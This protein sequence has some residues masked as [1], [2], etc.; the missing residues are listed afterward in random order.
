MPADVLIPA[1]VNTMTCLE[2]RIQSDKVFTFSSSSERSS[3][4][5]KKHYNLQSGFMNGEVKLD[6][7]SGSDVC[8]IL[9]KLFSETYAAEEAEEGNAFLSGK[10]QDNCEELLQ[11]IVRKCEAT[12]YSPDPL[13]VVTDF[14]LA[15]IRA[16]ETTFGP[17]VEIGM[18]NHELVQG[19]LVSSIA[20]L[21]HGGGLKILREL[22]K[23]KLVSYERGYRYD[24]YRLTNRGYDFLALRVLCSRNVIASVGNQ[25]GV[26][27]EADIY[28]V[29]DE[30]GKQLC[31]KLHRL[32]RT[33]FRRVKEKRD[34]HKH[35]NKASWLYLSRLAAL[36]EFSYMKALYNRGF[37]VPT[38][39]DFNRHCIIMELIDATLMC[40]VHEL[41][42]PAALYDELMNLILSFAN[43]G[44]IHCDFNEYN[45]MFTDSG[46]VRVIDFPQMISIS[47]PNAESYFDRDVR[48]IREFFKR[49]FNY[50]SELAPSFKDVLREDQLDVEISASGFTKDLETVLSSAL[51]ELKLEDDDLAAENSEDD[52]RL[53][54]KSADVEE[55]GNDDVHETLENKEYCLKSDFLS[56]SSQK[57]EETLTCNELK[58]DIP[59]NSSQN[60]EETLPCNEF[61]TFNARNSS[62]DND[63]DVESVTFSDAVS[64][65]TSA[66]TIAPEDIK[67]RVRDNL[68]KKQRNQRSKKLTAKG[69]A[70]AVTRTRRD[71]MDNI[72]DSTSGIWE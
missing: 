52:E 56:K 59:S 58:S 47:H 33:S 9:K 32:G 3:N 1:P 54:T 7:T 11:S 55:K 5:L 37:P 60:L 35:R 12:G 71:N 36:K 64:A 68:K 65:F 17:H 57:L 25:I 20:K 18:K 42:D 15:A 62:G 8:L 34:Y 40:H 43:H 66:S 24:G 10:S 53:D 14:E 63:S 6:G 28:V 38:P 23:H 50:E 61:G 2:L 67:S 4:I 26:G 29:G 46:K 21:K 69:D 27:K 16:V 22:S 45:L 48:C 19:P 41:D 39:I 13:T 72:K 70:N 49:K 30:E 31:L 51:D 44:I